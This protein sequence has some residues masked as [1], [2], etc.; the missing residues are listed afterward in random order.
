MEL[1]SESRPFVCQRCDAGF[2]AQTQLDT[3]M[4]L[5]QL[6]P[7]S[8]TTPVLCPTP[9]PSSDHDYNPDTEIHKILRKNHELDKGFN[10]LKRQKTN[11]EKRLY[12]TRYVVHTDMLGV[13]TSFR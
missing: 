1:H 5:H 9:M 2:K 10:T 3:H 7:L 6:A 12:N 8:S 11:L 13:P 4:K